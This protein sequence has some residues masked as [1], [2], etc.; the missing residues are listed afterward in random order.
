MTF[1]FSVRLD[2]P[3]AWVRSASGDAEWCSNT[4]KELLQEYCIN[5]LLIHSPGFES[6]AIVVEA[7]NT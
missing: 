2:M 1:R 4:L 5:K 3:D 7:P 6:R